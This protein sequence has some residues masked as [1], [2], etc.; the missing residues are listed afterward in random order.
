MSKY[1][2]LD[3]SDGNKN[4][5]RRTMNGDYVGDGK[6]QTK[7]VLFTSQLISNNVLQYEKMQSML[8]P[9]ST[10]TEAAATA[11]FSPLSTDIK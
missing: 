3:D 7:E 10:S 6:V 5:F 2:A 4:F 11:A 8:T 1:F 9:I